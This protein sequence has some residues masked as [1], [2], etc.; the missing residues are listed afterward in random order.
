M[1]ALAYEYSTTTNG[2]GISFNTFWNP[3]SEVSGNFVGIA[4]NGANWVMQQDLAGT[5]INLKDGNVHTAL[6]Q[7]DGAALSVTLDN[8]AI[9]SAYPISI[10]NAV[11]SAGQA[12][13][14]FSA[15]TG[16]AW[17]Q[18]DILNWSF[19]G[20][21]N[22]TLNHP[23]VAVPQT[24]TAQQNTSLPITLAATDAD[25][26]ALTFTAG[27]PV[28]GVLSGTAPNLNYTPATDYTGADQF[29][30]TANDG[31][32]TSAKALVSIQVMPVYRPPVARITVSPLA[33][34][35][36]VSGLTVIS[37]NN[38]NAPVLLDG[39]LSS[40]FN[41]APLTFA[42]SE[43]GTVF[44]TNSITTN[45]LTVGSHTIALTVSDGIGS[46]TNS[47]ILQVLA[48]SGLNC[49]SYPDFSSTNGLAVIGNAAQAGTNLRL[50]P[51]A[52]SQV[53]AFW[54]AT[55]LNCTAGF[56][57]TFQFQIS[58]LGGQFGNGADGIS[59]CIQNSSLSAES[60]ETCTPTNGVGVTF[61]TFQNPGEVSGNYVGIVR[62]TTSLTQHDLTGN[63]INLKDGNVHTAVVSYDGTALSVTIDGIVAI[64][65]YPVSLTNALNASGNGWVG[66]GA[67][68][69]GAWEQHDI[70]SWSFCSQ[71]NR[72]P[73]LVPM[74]DVRISSLATHLSAVTLVIVSPNGSN[75]LVTF[76]GS[77]SS[78]ANHDPLQYS[79]S[80]GAS[81]L[82][83]TPVWSH[84]FGINLNTVTL[85]VSNGTNT[86]TTNVSFFVMTP[87]RAVSGIIAQ[88]D[89]PA[90]PGQQP[91]FANI[92]P[93]LSALS[94]AHSFFLL[95]N[96][97]QGIS[98]LADFQNTLQ[99]Q[100]TASNS[101]MVASLTG[102][103]QDIIDAVSSGL[104]AVRPAALLKP[105]ISA[106]TI[107][108]VNR[109]MHAKFSGVPGKLYN[110]EASA[111]MIKWEVIGSAIADQN[112]AI[113]FIDGYAAGYPSR[114]YRSV[115]P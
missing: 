79:W 68:T 39:G 90:L 1:D 30:F 45:L 63:G 10:S 31:K 8:Q 111:D 48:A 56:T 109:A 54:Y 3:G 71:T 115:A 114:F 91:L 59:F 15:R 43:G 18:H 21:T 106:I 110:V 47:V 80:L 35:P 61:N 5:G 22:I 113:D 27:T 42:W 73:S 104:P 26:D 65:S 99:S 19:C 83:T 49:V 77:A 44:S 94:L 72:P 16:G 50:T 17:E 74:V 36:G 97:V 29:T 4:V 25:G 7:Y 66:F 89:T 20:L 84:S 85:A 108:N 64:S 14:G 40:D 38:S 69:G 88:L 24:L 55:P 52:A 32:A 96:M 92:Q 13:V 67:R 81:V 70:L 9:I 98:E 62:N 78:D 101:T 34:L 11:D 46:G 58:K 82:A 2:L 102:S 95:T 60:G 53:G 107:P 76:D 6:V 28:H 75:A 100:L 112:G 23:P 103:A 41:S 33:S 37:G 105:S 87:A 93:A 12:W 57:S 86:S 51:S